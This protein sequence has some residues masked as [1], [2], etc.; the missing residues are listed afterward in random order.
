MPDVRVTYTINVVSS[1]RFR[2]HN[3]LPLI[4][5]TALNTA[6]EAPNLLKCNHCYVKLE[7][8]RAENF[9]IG[10]DVKIIILVNPSF[11]REENADER[12]RQIAREVKRL[13]G[14]DL[15]VSVYLPA[16]K[17]YAELFMGE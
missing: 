12:A 4:V 17:G 13:I 1:L 14:E 5:A 7:F 8:V 11:K 16:I 3:A 10:P 6:E 15:S 9:Y 2:M